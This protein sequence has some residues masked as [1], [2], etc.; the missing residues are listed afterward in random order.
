MATATPAIGPP[1]LTMSMILGIANQLAVT[2]IRITAEAMSAPRRES[3]SPV[4]AR[5][6]RPAR[7]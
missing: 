7:W 2:T 6:R 5:N 1:P 4:K 3:R